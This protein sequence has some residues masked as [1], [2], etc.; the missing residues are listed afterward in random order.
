MAKTWEGEFHITP[1]THRLCLICK[2]LLEIHTGVPSR[3]GG[4]NW[5]RQQKK[6]VWGK[7]QMAKCW[8]SRPKNLI[9]RTKETKGPVWQLSAG[10]AV[11]GGQRWVDP[12]GLL[13]VQ[14][15]WRVPDQ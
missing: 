6:D 10:I 5:H 1:Q 9:P 4:W 8:L 3:M 13:P 15:T 14:P 12:W 7:A 11:L 2:A